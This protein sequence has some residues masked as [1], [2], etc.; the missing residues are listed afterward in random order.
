[1]IA[2]T[3]MEWQRSASVWTCINDATVSRQL[4][5]NARRSLQARLNL[6]SATDRIEHHLCRYA[7]AA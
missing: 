1:M 3:G 6:S 7:N 2:W 4:G 5:V